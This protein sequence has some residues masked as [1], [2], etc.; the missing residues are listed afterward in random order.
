MEKVCQELCHFGFN[1][2]VR[3]DKFSR[4]AFAVLAKPKCSPTAVNRPDGNQ[5]P[6]DSEAKFLHDFL[7]I[8][9]NLTETGP[10]RDIREVRMV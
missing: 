5:R 9:S 2:E 3:N 4:S 7:H 10:V 1:D 8:T 6:E